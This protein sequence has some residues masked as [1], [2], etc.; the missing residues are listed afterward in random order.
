MK[1]IYMENYYIHRY[2]ITAAD[3]DT[4]YRMTANA[5]LLYYQDCW[6]RYMSSLH[7]AAF[8]LVHKNRIWVI[9]EFNAWWE[10]QDAYWSQDVV[11]RVW[12][13]EAT[14]LRLFAEFSMTKPDGTPIAHGYG[15]WTLLDIESHRP[16]A[17]SEL[18]EEHLHLCGEE[19]HGKIR[20]PAGQQALHE[21]EHRV[22]PINLDFNGHVNNRTYLNIAMQSAFS[23]QN[24]PTA[25]ACRGPEQSAI[26][27]QKKLKS[28]TIRWLRETFLGDTLVCRLWQTEQPDA[29]LHVIS[30]DDTAVAQI[31]SCLADRTTDA[32][33]D[34]EAPRL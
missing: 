14:G 26:S 21:V 33:I 7:M 24:H 1:E 31:Y 34:D 12:N 8:D 4:H 25:Q 10:E 13:S 19:K 27:N 29:Y 6:A 3:M 18:G 16:V 2:S 28:L 5:V 20:I 9:T 15:C 30:K 23:Y 11:V 22:N 17:I 32:I